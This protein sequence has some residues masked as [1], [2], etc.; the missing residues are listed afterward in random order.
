MAG[1]LNEETIRQL[2]GEYENIDLAGFLTEVKE[3][4]S[5]L[6]RHWSEEIVAETIDTLIDMLLENC[7]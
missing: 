3:W 5:E 1:I 4:K 2:A 6:S 7:Y